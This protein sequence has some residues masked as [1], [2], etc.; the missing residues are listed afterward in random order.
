VFF[1]FR[2]ILDKG[3]AIKQAVVG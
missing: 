1:L 2:V 3:P